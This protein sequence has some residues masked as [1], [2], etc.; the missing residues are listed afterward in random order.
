MD[1]DMPQY[2]QHA[3]DAENQVDD[4]TDEQFDARTRRFQ[5]VLVVAG[6]CVIGIA[7]ALALM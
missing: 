5:A 1:S 6:V 4:I 2:I 7:V 3:D